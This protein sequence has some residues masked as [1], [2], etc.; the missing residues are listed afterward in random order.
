MRGVVEAKGTSHTAP[1]SWNAREQ[2]EGWGAKPGPDL[3]T[4]SLADHATES[5]LCPVAKGSHKDFGEGK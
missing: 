5:Q 2:C 1:V 3:I 4:E